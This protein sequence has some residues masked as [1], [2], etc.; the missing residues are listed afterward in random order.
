MAFARGGRGVL[1]NGITVYACCVASRSASAT[2]A[3]A[4]AAGLPIAACSSP[5]GSRL[6]T[7][8]SFA[9]R[10]AS[11]HLY[12]DS[13]GLEHEDDAII[14]LESAVFPGSCRKVTP[15]LSHTHDIP[16]IS[17]QS[18]SKSPSHPSLYRQTAN[19]HKNPHGGVCDNYSEGFL[20]KERRS[21]SEESEIRVSV[22]DIQKARGEQKRYAQSALP[23]T[24]VNLSTSVNVS[25]IRKLFSAKRDKDC[26]SKESEVESY[27][28]RRRE[29]KRISKAIC[30]RRATT[31]QNKAQRE[32]LCDNFVTNKVA[33]QREGE[34][35]GLS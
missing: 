26:Y 4:V 32:Y 25:N 14:A 17:L 20:S 33:Q 22:K 23:Q 29:S 15:F 31:H 5:S 8:S 3:L 7:S 24:K 21:Y 35:D 1:P 16:K 19:K 13:I 30:T 6:S 28:E 11:S 9:F 18:T 10:L 27:C 12:V 34:R 2:L